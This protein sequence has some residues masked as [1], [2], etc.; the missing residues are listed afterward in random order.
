MKDWH[1]IIMQRLN[2]VFPLSNATAY[3]M[4]LEF[5]LRLLY[6]LTA[7]DGTSQQRLHGDEPRSD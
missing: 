2:V 3:V 1:R 7:K 6:R 5:P 4:T